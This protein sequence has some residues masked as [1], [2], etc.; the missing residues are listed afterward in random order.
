MIPE[1]Y[2]DLISLLTKRTKGGNI[3]WDT[4]S[5]DSEFLTTLEDISIVLNKAVAGP[6]DGVPWKERITFSLKDKNGETI[7]EFSCNNKEGE[8]WRTMESLYGL[9]RRKAK[10][11][12]EAINKLTE[13]LESE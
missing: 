10:N 13:L 6:L 9:A 3:N 1:Q 11:I 5:N 7:D 12:D 2:K 8:D 4:G